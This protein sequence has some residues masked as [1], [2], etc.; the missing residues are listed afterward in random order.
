[1]NEKDL[2]AQ[3]NGSGIVDVGAAMAG[4]NADPHMIKLPNPITGVQIGEED[5]E[6][7]KEAR[8]SGA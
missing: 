4:R 5:E 3:P 2:S 8:A 7:E 1:V 6:E